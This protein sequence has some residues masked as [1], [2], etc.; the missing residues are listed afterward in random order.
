M[1]ISRPRPYEYTFHP[2]WFRLQLKDYLEGTYSLHSTSFIYDGETGNDRCF[3]INCYE[4]VQRH[5]DH[6]I[7]APQLLDDDW[8]LATALYDHKYLLLQRA[9]YFCQKGICDFEEGELAQYETL[10]QSAEIVMNRYLKFIV[11]NQI[12]HL[13]KIKELLVEMKSLELEL[14]PRLLTKIS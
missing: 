8:R 14:L 13:K 5:L 7:D 1:I 12:R 9:R 11:T 2:D 3:G 4:L 6:V 10:Y